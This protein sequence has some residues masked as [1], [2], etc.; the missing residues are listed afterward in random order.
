MTPAKLANIL[1]ISTKYAEY[2]LSGKRTPSKNTAVRFEA[3]T[4]IDRRAWL[5]PDE[6]PNAM[7][8]A[9]GRD[10]NEPNDQV[11]ESP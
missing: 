9:N 7:L 2:L 11:A 10:S 4:G 1:V 8:R 5:W 3:L 6:F